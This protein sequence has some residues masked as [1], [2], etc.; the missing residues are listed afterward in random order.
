MKA[1]K[2]EGFK[3]SQDNIRAKVA[4]SVLIAEY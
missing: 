1:K 4:P 2:L 3:A